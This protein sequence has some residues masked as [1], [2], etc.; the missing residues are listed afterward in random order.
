[1]TTTTYAATVTRAG[2]Y[3]HVAIADVPMGYTQARRLAEV[4][5]MARDLIATLLDVPADSFALVVHYEGTG[6]KD[7][8]D[9]S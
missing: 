9:V 5:P 4:E 6:R 8:H 7:D 1:M 3:W 2:A